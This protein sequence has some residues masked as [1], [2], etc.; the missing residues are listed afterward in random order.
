VRNCAE[1]GGNGGDGSSAQPERQTKDR[2]DERLWA[3]LPSKDAP[4]D[5]DK[6]SKAETNALVEALGDGFGDVLVQGAEPSPVPSTLKTGLLDHRWYFSKYS[7][8][9]EGYGEEAFWHSSNDDD[10]P[11]FYEEFPLGFLQRRL[12]VYF[13]NQFERFC[14]QLVR[15][16]PALAS[17]D[18][19]QE[20]KWFFEHR[21]CE[22]LY[23]KP[24]YEFHALQ[25]L[26]WIERPDYRPALVPLIIASFAGQLGRL[27]E[28][29]Y[30]RFRFEATTITGAGARKGASAGGRAKAR[31]HQA[32]HSAWQHAAS[33]IWKGRPELGKRAV[34]EIVRKKLREPPTAKHIARY[35]KHP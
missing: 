31:S 9:A 13:E 16:D 32:N 14:E 28:Q 22:L 5:Y 33:Q 20:D 21:A 12:R 3:L 24:W 4:Y 6:L 18:R 23:E 17:L 26:D 10:A 30:W 11:S 29:Y 19:L 8:C 27:V 7:K 34:A 2:R 35:I 25:F 1:K 15:E